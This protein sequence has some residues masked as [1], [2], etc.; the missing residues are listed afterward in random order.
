MTV[1]HFNQSLN[2]SINQSIIQSFRIIN[3]VVSWFLWLYRASLPNLPIEASSYLSITFFPLQ[4]YGLEVHQ[5]LDLREFHL[6][7]SFFLRKTWQ[8]LPLAFKLLAILCIICFLTIYIL[9]ASGTS[10]HRM[11]HE[12][13]PHHHITISSSNANPSP[14]L[15]FFMSNA[16]HLKT[17]FTCSIH[18]T[19]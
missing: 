4:N 11:C 6:D 8:K 14:L 5:T 19:H 12:N 3:D 9:P 10:D 13:K 2:L 18:V 16:Q 15:Y 17:P 1:A 7:Y